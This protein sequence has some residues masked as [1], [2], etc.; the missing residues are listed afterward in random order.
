MLN[1]AHDGRFF[2]EKDSVAPSGPLAEGRKEYALRATTV[3]LG[4]PEILVADEV[5]APATVIEKLWREARP[6]LSLTLITIPPYV[7]T[8]AATGV[9]LSWPVVTLN[10]AHD[11]LPVIAKVS[12]Y[13]AASEALGWK[14]Y[15]VPTVARVAGL[16]EIEI[17]AGVG[18][19]SAATEIVNAGND[20]VSEPS[21]TLIRIPA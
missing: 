20:A 3:V 5:A 13:P 17:V 15:A 21:L 11:G 16:P 7:P 4:V 14:R 1:V 8:S 18:G 6:W 12:A 19:A 10:V 2:T 9:P